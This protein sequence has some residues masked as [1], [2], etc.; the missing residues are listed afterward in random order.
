V[1]IAIFASVLH[2]LS[3]TEWFIMLGSVEKDHMAHVSKGAMIAV[4]LMFS[5]L[6]VWNP[7]HIAAAYVDRI[8]TWFAIVTAGALCIACKFWVVAK[9]SG[10]M[11]PDSIAIFECIHPIATLVT[12]I[13]TGNDFFE[14]R[15]ALACFLYFSGWILYPKKN[16]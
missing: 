7:Q 13:L 3:V 2:V 10:T 5:L 12:D 11:S 8:D 1:W 14:W 15:D 6:I 9:Y 4:I 16:I